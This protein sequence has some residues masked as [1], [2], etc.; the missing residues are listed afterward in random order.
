MRKKDYSTPKIPLDKVLAS[1]LLWDCEGYGRELEPA[2]AELAFC[3]LPG[4][5]SGK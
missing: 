4:R 3:G 5:L 2:A 1:A